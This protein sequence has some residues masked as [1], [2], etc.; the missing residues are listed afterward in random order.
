MLAA[1]HR[2]RHPADF[3]A[4]VRRGARAGRSAL[5]VHLLLAD[6]AA[7]AHPDPDHVPATTPARVGFVVPKAVGG[8]VIRHRVSRRLRAL[9]AARIDRL[10]PGSRLVVRALPPSAT[11]SS[12]VLGADLD[13]ALASAERRAGR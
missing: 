1:P 12:A 9:S 4:T 3:S 5:V 7:G 11:A 6:G 2:L 10:P 13:G 8:S